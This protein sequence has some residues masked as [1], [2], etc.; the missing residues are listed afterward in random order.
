MT[1]SNKSQRDIVDATGREIAKLDGERVQAERDVAVATAVGRARA[2]VKLGQV[3]STLADA[4]GRLL[5][6]LG[7]IVQNADTEIATVASKAK[8]ASGPAAQQLATAA[9]RLKDC[10]DAVVAKAASLKETA[11][12]RWSDAK[13]ELDVS[14]D[15]LQSL[16]ENQ[17]AGIN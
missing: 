8:T 4:H 6:Q 9:A 13:A 2:E 15:E 3:K 7:A 1:G 16:R 14:L 17:M 5:A 11:A 12:G 10:R